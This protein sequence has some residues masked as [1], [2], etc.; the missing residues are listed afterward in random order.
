MWELVWPCNRTEGGNTDWGCVGKRNWV[1]SESVGNVPLRKNGSW[2]REGVM[3]GVGGKGLDIVVIE[4]VAVVVPG[5]YTVAGESQ[6]CRL[7][8]PGY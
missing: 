2:K 3:E 8:L 4:V 5:W 1:C 6:A 7:N